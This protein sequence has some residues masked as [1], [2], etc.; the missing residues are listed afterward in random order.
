MSVWL[1]STSGQLVI[2]SEAP[3]RTPLGSARPLQQ[4]AN[5]T[6]EFWPRI[7]QM[8]TAASTGMVPMALV[9]FEQY[10]PKARAS[11][12]MA[13]LPTGRQLAPT[14]AERMSTQ[15]GS[16]SKYQLRRSPNAQKPEIAR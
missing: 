13:W 14:P 8:K 1:Q 2:R 7:C 10:F 4:C 12:I 6:P 5:Y 11:S 15:K 3:V 16:D 9:A